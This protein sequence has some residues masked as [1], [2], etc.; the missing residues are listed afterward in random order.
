MKKLL[1]MLA[2]V[3]ASGAQAQVYFE[4]GSTRPVN[5][6]AV[7]GDIARQQ[8]ARPPVKARAKLVR[9]R[10]GSRRSARMCRRVGGGVRR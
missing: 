8:R 10:D 3:F 9:C 2:L 1:C 6:G 4:S 7:N 5:P